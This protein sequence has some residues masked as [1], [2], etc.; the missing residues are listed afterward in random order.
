MLGG[1]DQDVL[2][3]DTDGKTAFEKELEY[4]GA[5]IRKHPNLSV[6]YEGKPLVLIYLGA[7][8]DATPSDHPL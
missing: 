1:I 8:Q 5:R 2:F 6:I 4:F 7:P 3:K